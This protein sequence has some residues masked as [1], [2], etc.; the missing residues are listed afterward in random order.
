M[1][2][3][4]DRNEPPLGQIIAPGPT[5]A[6]SIDVAAKVRKRAE[7]TPTDRIEA[8]ADLHITE[9]KGDKKT[10]HAELQV[11]RYS[12][13]PHLREDIRWLEGRESSL[14]NSLTALQTSYG[15]A[16]SFNWFSFALIAIGGCIVSYAAFLPAPKES[17]GI[18]MQR[19][20]A[21]LALASL[22]IG[23]I[24]QAIVSYRGTKT[25][26]RLSGV[27]NRPQ[28]PSPNPKSPGIPSIQ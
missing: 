8:R 11:V 25:L 24:V 5:S 13:L 10:L 7:L 27:D 16:I 15:W 12:E 28:R 2:N 1:A 22:L 20:V 6:P 14:Q 9:L 26:L 23:V 3:P 18:G 4:V 21:T 19:F 17:D